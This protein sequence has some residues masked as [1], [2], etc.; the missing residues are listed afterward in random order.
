ML[1]FLKGV[2]IFME[3]TYIAQD[4][5]RIKEMTRKHCIWIRDEYSKQH[6]FNSMP[7]PQ[8]NVMGKVAPIVAFIASFNPEYAW[9][10]LKSSMDMDIYVLDN[11]LKD[12][13][14]EGE[15][16][17]NFPVSK[18]LGD[19]FDRVNQIINNLIRQFP[20]LADVQDQ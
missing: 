18:A 6:P 16:G 14:K 12:Y 7:W 20:H 9:N 8:C 10:Q 1:I 4:N 17:F 15:E 19:D 2:L 13:F 5:P 3:E 11:L